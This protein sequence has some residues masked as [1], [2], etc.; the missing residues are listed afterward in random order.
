MGNGFIKDI[1]YLVD[2]ILDVIYSSGEECISC[3][4]YTGNGKLLCRNCT[5]KIKPCNDAFDISVKEYKFKCYSAAYYSGLVKELIAR[6]KYKSDFKAGEALVEYMLSTIKR[7]NLKFDIITYVP[8]TKKSLR[9]R[10][11]NQSKYI[12][13]LIGNDTNTKVIPLLKKIRDTKDQIGLNA[14][15]RWNNL[16]NSY[17]SINSKEIHGKTIL[18]I[19]DVVTTGATAFYC[20]KDMV[21]HGAKE[22]YIATA[23]RSNIIMPLNSIIS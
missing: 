11:Y 19:D 21:E 14:E 18:L 4:E 15:E 10:G 16:E 22:V 8:L 5:L 9:K 12:A 20:A 7:H 2:C 3:K 6:L 1:K 13:K 17:K 23:A